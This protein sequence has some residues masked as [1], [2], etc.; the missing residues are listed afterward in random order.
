MKPYW[1][2]PLLTT[3]VLS[4]IASSANAQ[5][6]IAWGSN[7]QGATTVPAAATNVVAVAAGSFHSVGLR[8][9]GTVVC[10]GAIT[11]VPDGATNTIS[12]AAGA[13]HNLALQ[14]DG[15]IL[16]WGNNNAYG[17]T[18]VPN[19][20][21]NVIA[22]AAGNYHN[23]ALRA[24][25]TVVA[26]GKSTYGQTNVP[27]NVKVLT[28][29]AGAEHSMFTLE[30]GS[31]VITGG[32]SSFPYT[33]AR[34]TPKSLKDSVAIS[35]SAYHNL[36]LRASGTV[37]DWGYPTMVV[38]SLATNVVAVAA[39]TNYSM[40]L[41]S[42]GKIVAWGSS[43]TSAITN[44]P[45]S[46]SNVIAI[47][48][49]LSHA[50][51]V[52]GDGAPHILGPAAYRP[53][54]S[55]AA[56]LPLFVRAV[57]RS[58]LSFTWLE[59]NVPVLDA[60]NAHPE[61]IAVYGNDGRAYSAIISNSLGAVTSSVARVAVLAVNAWGNNLDGQTSIPTT[62]GSP[63]AIRAGA[64]H[65]LA[66]QPDGSV[67]A[68]G[69]NTSGQTNVPASATNVVAIAAGSDHSLALRT[70]GSLIAWGRN[71]DGQTDIPPTATNVVA[72]AAGWAHSV[73]LRADGTVVAWGNNDYGQTAV[74]F[75]ATEVT[76]IA[77][78]YYHT[79]ALRTDGSVVSWG[80]L[81]TVPASATNVVA[82]AAGWGHSLA[83][84]ADGS[85]VAW[86]DNTYGQATV[87][88]S[89]TNVVALAA[90][91]YCSMALR[92]DG[93]VIA[94]G[95]GALGIT[96]VPTGLTNV[97]NIAAGEDHCL[98]VVSDG[99]PRFNRQLET[100]V[101]HA[102]NQAVL[103]ASL[104]GAY[105]LT[106][107]WYHDGSE[108]S[109]ATN[110]CL[111]LAHAE[112]ADSGSYVLVVSNAYGQIAGAPITLTVQ[113]DPATLTAV[114][115]WGSDINGQCTIP[116]TIV[117]PRAIASGGFHNLALQAD[118]TVLAW[119]KNS[120]GQVN[121]PASATNIVAI[122]AGSDHSMALRSDGSVVAWGRNWDGQTDVPPSVTNATAISAGWAHSVAL[123]P[124]GTVVAWGNND[125]GQTDV[126]LF[127][128]NVTAV[129]SGY[130]HN[131]ALC[132]DHTIVGWG[133]LSAVPSTA[134]NV[135]AVAAG[136]EHSLALRA[137][138][139]VVAW[140]D[141]SQG[142]STVPA[143]A[144]N[145][146]AISAGY[147]H[148]MALLADG[149]LIAW[150]KGAYGMTNVPPALRNVA[151]IAAGED[152]ELAMIEL[153]PPRFEG[154]PRSVVA[155]AGRNALLTADAGGTQ[156]MS[157]QWFHNNAPVS[158]E[159]NRFLILTNVQ[160]DLAGAYILVAA[161]STGF[162]ATNTLNLTVLA[163][164]FVDSRPKHIN[165]RPG[166]PLCISATTSG[167]GPLN[168]QW[169][170]N[171]TNV[172]ETTRI[173]GANSTMLCLAPATYADSGTYRILASNPYGTATGIVAEVSVTPVVV[174]GDD[175]EGRLSVPMGT[176]N[177]VAVASSGDH[178]LALRGDGTVVAW[179]DNTFGQCAVPTSATNVIAVAAGT[180]HSL[181]LDIDGH[182]IAWG[183]NSSDQI[184]V[185]ASLT[186]AIA[187]A[188]GETHSLALRLDGSVVAWGGGPGTNV[189]A[190]ATNVV[191]IAAGGN[192]SIAL[193]AGGA[194]TTWGIG[195]LPPN[196]ATN[197]ISV[198][199]GGTHFLALQANRTIVGWG[200][201]YYGQTDVPVSA[202]N[203]VD[204]A[205]AD[206][207]SMALRNDG[208]VVEWGYNPVEQVDLAESTTNIVRIAAGSLHSLALANEG[209]SGRS[210]PNR[211]LVAHAGMPII[212]TAIQSGAFPASYQWFHGGQPVANATNSSLLLVNIQP[213][214]AGPYTVIAT[215]T[216]GNASTQLVTVAIDPQPFVAH[217]VSDQTVLL[218]SPLCISPVV[219]GEQPIGF[220]WRHASTNLID[221]EHVSGTETASLCF[222]A[223]RTTDIGDYS[224][225]LTNA[226]GSVSNLIMRLSVTPVAGWGLG[227]SGQTSTPSTATN[228]VTIAAGYYHSLALRADG[229]VVAWGSDSQGQTD[230][231]P[232]AE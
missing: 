201:N 86:G 116:P 124:D 162:A 26:W 131:L 14:S 44:V 114:G 217:P 198:A 46:A 139:S 97:V 66:L 195:Y 152:H 176:T 208:T 216:L 25:G 3:A 113:S 98:A 59:D 64:F 209:S 84:H 180:S 101:V 144:T 156:P 6:V 23:L 31:I 56:P 100:P 24:D 203:I 197:T 5:N 88:A 96:N 115:A 170:F 141:N 123:R 104:D 151:R 178:S 75:L 193:Q 110:R 167:S 121:V 37:F 206:S 76:A 174:W 54:A 87:P 90:G 48:A 155:H 120:S 55:V 69:K 117:N 60:T 179:G 149:T 159:T 186:N 143:G 49:G 22:I 184:T 20:A 99:Q 89:A 158:G 82:I 126:P 81:D 83:L 19:S 32:T 50:L 229:S 207:R 128:N 122:A 202:T 38:P 12:I 169:Q 39:G 18:T 30:D 43:G 213:T 28:I 171:G 29:A 183:D 77:A 67:V 194:I 204:I 94:W 222:T 135:V 185:P 62:L 140:G 80:L 33:Q 52:I 47:A 78:G 147:G 134:T 232:L 173:S 35:A 92:A 163:P 118:G 226:H 187:I 150:G 72:I 199:A 212:L 160:I 11:N 85:V 17:Q 4:I 7:L 182:V 227:S 102:G 13:Y 41:R 220:Q 146:V 175:S 53:N 191:A 190:F 130:Y 107:Q 145:V 148:S 108:V 45:L 133:S 119:G 211:S 230:V 1:S 181:A 219:Y 79:L 63:S 165:A 42:D 136:W 15:S 27:A 8:N 164:P 188:A 105:P 154:N 215:N 68:W 95:K 109:G 161:N 10:W 196:T 21:T 40:A 111:T 231:P 168:V 137:D 189:P 166:E 127:L 73:A 103:T 177:V 153:G 214:D 224:L 71:W 51:A 36:A 65:N 57:G 9:D 106:Y 210:S 221:D 228:V 205:A 157:Y 74:S 172:L 218:R 223:T 129:S 58:P 225:A 200:R 112:L 142:Q 91:F 138:G 34:S 125:Y 93:S 16:A 132:A 70:D 2:K 192:G 61:I